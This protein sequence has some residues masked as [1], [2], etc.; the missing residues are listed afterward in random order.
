VIEQVDTKKKNSFYFILYRKPNV[1][2][3]NVSWKAD[4]SICDTFPPPKCP[5][6]L[7]TYLGETK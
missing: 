2:Y 4:S 3:K 7:A 1:I 6:S 5:V